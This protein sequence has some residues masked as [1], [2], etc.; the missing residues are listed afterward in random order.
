MSFETILE[1]IVNECG[2]GRGIALMGTDGIPIVQIRG[3]DSGENPLGGDFSAAGVEVG[4]IM[5]EFH[6][7]SD[8]L[9]AGAVKEC[10]LA[11]ARFTLILHPVDEEVIL[12][13]ALAPDGNLGK[14]RYLIRRHLNSLREE[15]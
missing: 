1:T 2:G 3:D 7:V 8:V 10:T 5:S 9:G 13:I 4:R 15:L 6:K 11:M 14:A 12:V